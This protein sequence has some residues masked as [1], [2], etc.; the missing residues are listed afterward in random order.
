M[1][2]ATMSYLCCQKWIPNQVID[3]LEILQLKELLQNLAV[4]KECVK[5]ENTEHLSAT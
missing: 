1:N 3:K 4:K 2:S 5:K